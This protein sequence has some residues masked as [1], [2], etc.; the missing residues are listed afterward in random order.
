PRPEPP[1]VDTEPRAA[2][3][4]TGVN[5]P[6]FPW[7][8]PTASTSRAFSPDVDAG[9][10]RARRVGEVA[11]RVRLITAAAGYDKINF[12]TAPGGF[13]LV[14]RL[15]QLEADTGRPLPEPDRWQIP[16]RPIVA[17][18]GLELLLDAVRLV[19]NPGYFRVFVFVL[20][21]KGVET[22][23]ADD[24]EAY[25]LAIDWAQR[26]AD[27]LDPA[28][29]ALPVTPDHSLLVLVYEFERTGEKSEHLRPS[30]WTLDDHLDSIGASLK[31][32]P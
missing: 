32:L 26:G 18:F 16:S 22:A 15:E 23:P 12:Y 9:R 27:V 19:R 11:D 31:S 3:P 2:P 8:P 6:L 14:T 17:S 1:R 24:D 29:R 13:A 25:R 4:A 10:P 20:T 30:R 7:P 21:N 5:K 28:I